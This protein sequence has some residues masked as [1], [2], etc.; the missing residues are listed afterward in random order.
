MSDIKGSFP[1]IT[2]ARLDFIV[3]A[4]A[5]KGYCKIILPEQ[6]RRPRQGGAELW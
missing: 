2:A 5:A 4:A 1:F 6:W 3:L